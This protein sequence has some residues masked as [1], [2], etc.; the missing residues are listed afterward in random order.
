MNYDP[1]SEKVPKDTIA[2]HRAMRENVG[3]DTVMGTDPW[4]HTYRLEAFARANGLAYA[5]R[6]DATPYQQASFHDN[7]QSGI[8]VDRLSTL[9]GGSA[10]GRAAA[11]E[12]V[13]GTAPDYRSLWTKF[14]AIDLGH[15]LPPWRLEPSRDKD[16]PS[17]L[18]QH[19]RYRGV[20][21]TADMKALLKKQDR[22]RK[23]NRSAGFFAHVRQAS[24]FSKERNAVEQAGFHAQVAELFDD[25]LGHLIVEHAKGFT[26]ETDQTRLL[27]SRH[28]YT[29]DE[30]AKPEVL[31]QLFT[32][33]VMLGPAFAARIPD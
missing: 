31:R 21:S 23:K 1:L 14:V 33:A 11:G 8:Y 20:H 6:F 18:E 3:W 30:S 2:H 13:V 9:G 7:T 27:I 16:A 25:E 26:L 4:L 22:E 17:E 19:F 32:M 10:G 15:T 24:E 5:P 29:E 28:P 12:V